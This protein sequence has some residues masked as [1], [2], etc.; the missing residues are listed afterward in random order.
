M[1]TNLEGWQR[2]S[3]HVVYDVLIKYIHFNPMYDIWQLFILWV[4]IL[5]D[6]NLE[7]GWL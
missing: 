3:N 4:L 1:N 7:W 2:V 5:N 6:L